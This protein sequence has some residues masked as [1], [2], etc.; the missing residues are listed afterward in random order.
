MCGVSLIVVPILVIFVGMA[1]SHETGD[2]YVVYNSRRMCYSVK[3]DVTW[4]GDKEM[5][6]YKDMAYNEAADLIKKARQ[7][8]TMKLEIEK[9]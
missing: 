8:K 2:Y 9:K 3:V 7:F 1:S 6:C 5:N 4:R